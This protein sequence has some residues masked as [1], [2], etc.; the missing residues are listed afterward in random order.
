MSSEL[1]WMPQIVLLLMYVTPSAMSIDSRNFGNALN[2]FVLTDD[3]PIDNP[4]GK[5]I[6]P[7]ATE[8]TFPPTVG[9]VGSHRGWRYQIFRPQKPPGRLFRID[10]NSGE[11]YTQEVIDR[12]VVCATETT[13]DE[14]DCTLSFQV[15]A[16]PRA[17]REVP[18]FIDVKVHVMDRND[19]VPAFPDP[20]FVNLSVSEATEVGARFPLPLARDP[21][22]RQFSVNAYVAEPSLPDEWALMTDK[23]PTSSSGSSDSAGFQYLKSSHSDESVIT[24]LYLQLRKPLD[25]ERKKSFSFKIRALDDSQTNQFAPLSDRKDILQVYINVEDINDNGPVFRPQGNRY[26]KASPDDQANP[27]MVTY[28]AT[29]PESKW[30]KDPI[31]ILIADDIDGPANSKVNYFFAPGSGKLVHEYFTLNSLNGYLF[32]RKPL[33]YELQSEYSFRVIATDTP[34]DNL[35]GSM[36][37]TKA[38]QTSSTTHTATARVIITVIDTNDETPVIEVDFLSSESSVNKFAEI[39]ENAEPPQFIASIQATDRDAGPNGQVS[40]TQES[41]SSANLAMGSAIL[42]PRPS[43]RSNA[44]ASSFQLD[45]IRQ[46]KGRVQYRLLTRES[47]DREDLANAGAYRQVKII[48]T[49][50]GRP[51]RSSSTFVSIRLRDKNDNAPTVSLRRPTDYGFGGQTDKWPS[52][53]ENTLP[54]SLVTRLNATDLDEGENGRLTFGFEA[55]EPAHGPINPSNLFQINEKTGDI[56]TKVQIDREAYEPPLSS[57]SLR[58]IVTDNGT[59]PK[60]ATQDVTIHILDENDNA[61]SFQRPEYQFHVMENLPGGHAIGEILVTDKDEGEVTLSFGM[62]QYGP[63][64]FVIWSS[65]I[66]TKNQQGVGSVNR[67]ILNTTRPLDRETENV[68]K[69]TVLATDGPSGNGR[70]RAGTATATVEVIVENENDNDPVIIFPQKQNK[71]FYLS[72]RERKNFEV[73]TINANDKDPPENP[74]IFE[75]MKTPTE[76]KTANLTNTTATTANSGEGPDFLEIEPTTGIVYL[77]RDMN[78]DDKGLHVFKVQVTDAGIPPR[79]S[80]ITFFVLVDDSAPRSVLQ[81]NAASPVKPGVKPEPSF[82]RRP[83]K[84]QPPV[85]NSYASNRK[86]MPEP[87]PKVKARVAG[88]LIILLALGLVFILLLLTLGLVAY[89]RYWKKQGRVAPTSGNRCS[90]LFANQANGG[91]GGT[92]MKEIRVPTTKKQ[93]EQ[94]LCTSDGSIIGVSSPTQILEDG[95]QLKNHF[96]AVIPTSDSNGNIY[97]KVAT[98]TLSTPDPEIGCPYSALSPVTSV[99]LKPNLVP[100]S[101]PYLPHQ[102]PQLVY[103]A[104]NMHAMPPP[105]QT[106]AKT[107]LLPQSRITLDRNTF[108]NAAAIKQ[109]QLHQQHEILAVPPQT[110]IQGATWDSQSRSDI[111]PKPEERQFILQDDVSPFCSPFV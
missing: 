95:E 106:K 41:S 18:T 89:L 28:T 6:I 26:S 101:E 74:H 60:S 44:S 88:D 75:L 16:Q 8:N 68:F 80:C 7:R 30:I 77:S 3:T 73:L 103:Y 110:A 20:G 63:L 67:F 48:C 76:I 81:E 38:I 78:N 102:D 37:Q 53:F 52:V 35:H 82:D 107:I 111:S 43:S 47:L 15:T 29:V 4:V 10:T 11:L 69:F 65:P 36:H 2:E 96:S 100:N 13:D 91:S 46:E 27:W 92:C 72:W 1:I 66:H 90:L 34:E 51:A 61:P 49:D 93:P 94:W 86:L 64:P 108:R 109:H 25:H 32:L 85:S 57:V 84:D 14:T 19:H 62:Q 104:Q 56:T 31:L 33:D 70:S 23:S 83:P 45:E 58:V 98:D 21:D 79:S 40:C 55:I 24:G 105:S 12:E 9:S 87:R 22:T 59:P 99:I 5:V 71:T 17:N 42:W 39:D 97:Y 50:A 54:G